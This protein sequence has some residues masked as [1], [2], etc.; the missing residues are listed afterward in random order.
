MWEGSVHIW[1]QA[2]ECL[3]ALLARSLLLGGPLKSRGSQ[4]ILLNS[5]H[6]ALSDFNQ[7]CW[8]LRLLKLKIPR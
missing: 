5:G 6:G 8:N 2:G 1:R 3:G 7:T 4:Q